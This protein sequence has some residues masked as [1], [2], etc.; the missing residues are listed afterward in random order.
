VA[1]VL[2]VILLVAVVVVAAVLGRQ[3]T[4]LRRELKEALYRRPTPDRTPPSTQ[5]A[6]GP[7]PS[8]AGPEAEPLA[9]A[10]RVETQAAPAGDL[11]RDGRLRSLW[12]LTLLEQQRQWQLTLPAGSARARP[13]D[14]LP[15]AL[16]TEVERIREE[17]GTPGTLTVDAPVTTTQD[18]AL[19]FHATRQLLA[20]LVP[21]TQAFDLVLQR[22]EDHAVVELTCSG[23]EGPD[24][25]AEGVAR[26]LEAVAPAGGDLELDTLPDD[27]LQATLQLPLR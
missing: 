10:P 24:Q 7:D 11:D 16:D 13:P 4:T 19:V 23:W 15:G 17:V 27:R 1:W 9:P 25:V 12:A 6:P 14:D 26:L 2:A 22:K 8:P 21:H 3:I 18:D 20:L 5:P